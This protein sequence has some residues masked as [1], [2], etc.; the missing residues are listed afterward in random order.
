MG[1]STKYCQ[2]YKSQTLYYIGLTPNLLW[3]NEKFPMK[4]KMVLRNLIKGMKL[5]WHKVPIMFPY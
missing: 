3:F 1:S 2:Y 4:I 5:K